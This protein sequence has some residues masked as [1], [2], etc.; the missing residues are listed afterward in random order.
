[1]RFSAAFLSLLFLSIFSVEVIAQ[2]GLP[3]TETLYLRVEMKD[4]QV[5]VGRR[6][7]MTTEDLVL[8][9]DQVGKLNIPLVSVREIREMSR[10]ESRGKE[11]WHYNFSANQNLA[12]PNAFG[13]RKREWQ[14]HNFMFAFNQ[15]SYGITDWLSIH[16]AVELISPIFLG[17]FEEPGGP[18][19]MLRPQ[20]SWP[21]SQGKV[22]IG[23]GVMI[24][25]LPFTGGV[26]DV[27]APYLQISVGD[28]DNNLNIAAG[29]GF[30]NVFGPSIVY[31]AGGNLRLTKATSLISEHWFFG[32]SFDSVWVGSL[33]CR[34]SGERFAFSAA[35]ST[36][37]DGWGFHVVPL[38][39]LS[40]TSAIGAKNLR[41]Y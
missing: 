33:G 4:G 37:A 34:F 1:M 30:G 28:R 2:N 6:L 20:V 15:L 5:L 11:F 31:S 35:L 12:A 32:T 39:M 3:A 10:R 26:L 29:K 14:Y 38:P 25:G 18:G 13:L 21:L 24:A 16:S 19:F 23:G 8:E 36:V 7:A 40:L 17:G 41:R 9:T 27:T 22:A